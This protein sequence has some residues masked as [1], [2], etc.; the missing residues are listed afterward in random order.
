MGCHYLDWSVKTTG[1][2][3]LNVSPFWQPGS[4]RYGDI[5]TPHACNYIDKAGEKIVIEIG[6]QKIHIG[7]SNHGYLLYTKH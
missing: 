4:K 1:W 6:Q 5:A 7:H 3:L 2:L